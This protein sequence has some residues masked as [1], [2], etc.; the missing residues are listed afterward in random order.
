MTT[1][2]CKTCKKEELVSLSRSKKYKYCSRECMGIDHQKEHNVTCKECGKTFRQRPDRLKKERKL[3]FFCSKS[4]SNSYKKRV[5]LGE[6]NPNF[7]ASYVDFDGYPLQ[8]IP[9][10]GRVKEHIY[11]TTTT[12]GIDKIHK[13]YHVHH[14]DCNVFNNEPENLAVLS[15]SDHQ[16]IH[17]Q[18]GN[19]TLW[20]FMNKKVSYDQLVEWS[21]DKDKC[22]LLLVNLINQKETNEFKSKN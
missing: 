3:G 16:W 21:N 9:Q 2:N 7:K 15:V 11:V 1:V 18:F 19:A 4:C 17:K 6:G 22:K 5:Y 13:G 10:I 8:H 20:A 12:L 14:R